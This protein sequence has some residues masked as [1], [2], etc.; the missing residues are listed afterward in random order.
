MYE[1]R[2]EAEAR[3]EACGVPTVRLDHSSGF[4]Q[5]LLVLVGFHA[6]QQVG[7]AGELDQIRMGGAQHLAPVDEHF[8]NIL[9]PSQSAQGRHEF[10]SV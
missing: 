8:V 9:L 7:V 3:S 5:P 6:V 2:L 10:G 4:G 1:P